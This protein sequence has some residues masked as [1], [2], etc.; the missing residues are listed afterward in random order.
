MQL[1]GK[2]FIYQLCKHLKTKWFWDF[3]GVTY[4]YFWVW[5]TW[6]FDRIINSNS[7]PS[8]WVPRN[9][10]FTINLNDF[11]KNSLSSI[12][13]NSTEKDTVWEYFDR[14]KNLDLK[15]DILKFYLDQKILYCPY[16]WLNQFQITWKSKTSSFD[17]DHFLPKSLFSNYWLSLYNLFP[18]CKYCNM[19]WM[20]WSR[21][22]L[23]ETKWWC[24][25]HPIRWRLSVQFNWATYT[26]TQINQKTFD[27]IF[28]CTNNRN[29]IVSEP[30]EASDPKYKHHIIFFKLR[31]LYLKSPHLKNDLTHIKNTHYR[32]K[33]SYATKLWL[34]KIAQKQMFLHLLEWRYP[35]IEKEILQYSWWKLK[36]DIIQKTSTMF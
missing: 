16:C 14:G 21:N 27:D 22:I 20:K 28:D 2:D 7:W 36:K 12:T 10:S 15:K 1:L 29:G 35:Q 31:E 26:L 30:F 32:I 8:K 17:L 3:Y 13:Q 34:D 4:K 5:L 23:E 25:F 6:K 24:I 19:S 11:D 9:L 18:A 33:Q